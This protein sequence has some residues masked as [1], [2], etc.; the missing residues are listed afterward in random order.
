[1][2]TSNEMLHIINSSG[3]ETLL[4]G[5][6]VRMQRDWLIEIRNKRKFTQ[7]KV[8]DLCDI[9]RAYYTMIENGKRRP[10]VEVAKKIADILSF[11]WA[12]FFSKDGNESLLKP[13]NIA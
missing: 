10:S 6:D 1:M 9:N 5:G 8:A 2:L 3:N 7:K 12:I 13:I 11:D 4:V